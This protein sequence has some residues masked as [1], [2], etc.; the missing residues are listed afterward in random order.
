MALEI[1]AS[2]YDIENALKEYYKI[3]EKYGDFLE[4]A[5]YFKNN[6]NINEIKKNEFDN[7]IY[8]MSD[9]EF[10][11]KFFNIPLNFIIPNNSH[12]NEIYIE[13]TTIPNNRDVFVI[14]HLE[15]SKLNIHSHKY[16]EINYVVKGHA[17][18]KFES[19][20]TVLNEGDFCII[21]PNSS[22]D[23]IIEEDSIVLDIMIRKGVF[24]T[25][26]FTFVAENNILADFFRKMLYGDREN[27]NYILFKTNKNKQ[28]DYFV[29]NTL[30]ES[31]SNKIN[32]NSCCINWVAILFNTILR[33]HL[34]YYENKKNHNYNFNKNSD[35]QLLLQYIHTNYKSITLSELAS[36]FN[37]SESYLSNLIKKKFNLS[38][39]EMVTNIK[40]HKSLS[41]L[42]NTD[43]SVLD[44]SEL[45]GYNSSDHFSR[46]FKKIYGMSPQKY[47][48]DNILLHND[49]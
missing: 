30:L 27:S 25:T 33:D 20:T 4:V 42:I 5:H 45:V 35:L 43:L 7:D 15:Y 32:S 40:L 36:K 21:A 6:M 12:K 19:E 46:T 8:I 38:F 10:F 16:F 29:R 13:S 23:I 37:Y 39:I 11:K 24:D 31:Y 1:Y 17:T 18:Q 41:Y 2:I 47:R 34:T 14:K 49:K 22:H 9:D 26:F 48:I 3:H 28:I 44:I